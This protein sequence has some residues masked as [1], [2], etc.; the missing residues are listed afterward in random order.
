MDHEKLI[1][2]V[3]TAVIAATVKELFALA[4]WIITKLTPRLGRIIAPIF[5]RNVFLILFIVQLFGFIV[6]LVI[7]LQQFGIETPMTNREIRRS[8][9]FGLLTLLAWLRAEGALGTYA[10]FHGRGLL[11]PWRVYNKAEQVAAPN[12]SV[13]PSLNSESTVRGSE[14]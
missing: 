6:M 8:I 5:Q 2:V 14:G 13:T 1:I 12:R 7:F 10:K 4:K 3:V 9:V 11:A